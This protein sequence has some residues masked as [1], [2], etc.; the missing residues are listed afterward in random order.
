MTQHQFI[1]GAMLGVVAG[2]ALGMAMS[3]SKKR[4]IRKA[5]DKAIKAVG[6]VV[7]NLSENFG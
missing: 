2:T 1:S 6:E 7:D 3:T 5:A 4:E